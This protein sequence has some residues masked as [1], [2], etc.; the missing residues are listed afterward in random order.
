MSE[1]VF[2]RVGIQVNRDAN[3]EDV[4]DQPFMKK[5]KTNEPNLNN[6]KLVN[7]LHSFTCPI[8][9]CTFTGQSGFI[10]IRNHLPISHFSQQII[11]IAKLKH[12]RNQVPKCVPNCSL[13]ELEESGD[14]V[15]HY[16]ILHCLVDQ[17]FQEFAKS[18]LLSKFG[19]LYLSH[20][21]PYDDFICDDQADLIKHLTFGHYYTLIATEVK[22]L[23][24]SEPKHSRDQN[25]EVQM[26]YTCPLCTKTFGKSEFSDT[27]D[28]NALISHF[29][30]D[31]CFTY[32]HLLTDKNLSK[33]KN[34]LKENLSESEVEPDV[35]LEVLENDALAVYL[36]PEETN[37]NYGVKM[38]PGEFPYTLDHLTA[39]SFPD[40]TRYRP[41]WT[42]MNAGHIK[43]E[44]SFGYSRAKEKSSSPRRNYQQFYRKEDDKWICVTCETRYDST[45]GIH[46][47]L[48][49][50]TC[51]FGD[52]ERITPKKDFRGFYIREEDK[53]ICLGCNQRYDTI[54]G[55]HYHL[56]NKKCGSEVKNKVGNPYPKQIGEKPKK[57]SV[58]KKNYLQFYKKQDKIC[59]CYGCGTQYQSVHG[60]HN[61]LNSTK[62]GFGDK[63][64]SNPKT[65]YT[66]FYRKEDDKLICIACE[67]QYNSMHG[68]HYHL[69]STKCGFG[70]KEKVTPKK[71]YQEFYTKFENSFLCNRC[72]F[73]IE[74]LQGIH[75]HIRTCCGFNNVIEDMNS[76][77][78]G[79]KEEEEEEELKASNESENNFFETNMNY[80]GHDENL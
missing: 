11:D 46:Y 33:K 43:A 10:E 60:M 63:F 66:Q 75:R 73:K 64:K 16:G 30:S 61:H 2:D 47:H 65:S 26:E 78:R 19:R 37:T 41:I 36:S 40:P 77:S 4:E 48:N 25:G 27:V 58:P 38:E 69:N 15:H 51:G 29:G 62:C 79:V 80:I 55:V 52:K 21:C 57:P 44:S 56:S 7:K 71:N 12:S 67:I 32:Y 53:F 50:T 5:V 34:T 24:I 8:E 18:F 22:H 20:T 45:H 17:L 74:Y 13:A 23:D 59:I 70:A 3:Q 72:N 14:L 6:D 28:I 54:R 49:H 31:H 76:S 1:E 42:L 9:E 39:T 68:M 35:K